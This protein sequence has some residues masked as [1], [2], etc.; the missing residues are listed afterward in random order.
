MV[1]DIPVPVQGFIRAVNDFIFVEDEPQQSDIIFIPGA[2]H[3]EHALRAAQLYHQGMAKYLL[4]SGR[5]GI[6]LGHFKGV[7]A[8]FQADYPES[9]ETEWAFLRAVLMKAGVP[10]SAILREDQA[11]YTWANAQYSRQVTDSL[12]LT[13]RRGLLCCRSFHAR[14]ALLYYQAAFPEADLRVCPTG[15]SGESREDWFLTEK[16]RRRVLGEVSRLGSQIREVFG[17]IIDGREN[18]F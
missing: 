7:P 9:Y 15:I 6:A 2:S 1:T 12:G 11:T 16:G 8:A 3:P 17:S 5:Y 13:I 18:P 10:D 14:R 4:P